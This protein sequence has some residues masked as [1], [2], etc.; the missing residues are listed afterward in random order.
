MD[1]SDVELAVI[2]NTWKVPMG[3]PEGSGQVI[4]Y[5]FF[6]KYPHNMEYFEAFKGKP[7]KEAKEDA[8]FKA[9]AGRIVR[10]FDNAIKAAEER[11]KDAVLSKAQWDRLA[12]SHLKRHI[13]KDSFMELKGIV[14]E[15][16]AEVCHLNDFQSTA[17][18]K[19]LNYL[20]GVMLDQMTKLE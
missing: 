8:K 18:E 19:L 14:L 10:A 4:L 5:R 2:M 7:L 16:L 15:V 12:S 11:G 3:D 6:E 20:F 9:H 13:P 1:L 17:W